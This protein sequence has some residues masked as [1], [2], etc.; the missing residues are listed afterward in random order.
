M[1]EYNSDT[2]RSPIIALPIGRLF[3]LSARRASRNV[4]HW[5]SGEMILRRTAIGLFHAKPSFRRIRGYRYLPLL[6]R[7]PDAEPSK[8]DLT[9]A[10]A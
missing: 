5:R 9:E 10:A 6:I 8:L 3:A 1:I 7:A 2:R 4:T